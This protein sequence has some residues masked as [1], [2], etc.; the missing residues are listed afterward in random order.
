MRLAFFLIALLAHVDA[1]AQPYPN[2]PVRFVVGFTPGGSSDTVARIVGQRLGE[3]LGQQVV[4]DNRGGASGGVAAELVAKSRPDGYTL[5]LATPGSLTIAPVLKKHLPYDPDRELAPVTQIATTSAILLTTPSGPASVRDL[6]AAAKK[7]PR[8]L[9][10]ASSG[11]G[12]SNHLAAELFNTMAGIEMVHVPYKGSGQTLPALLSGEV[13]LVFGPIV[14][15]LPQLR[16][17]RVKALGVTGARRSQAAPDIPT[18]AEAGLPGFEIDS[19]YG[20]A[21]AANTPAPILQRL[22]TE[23][24]AIVQEREVRERLIREGADPVGSTPQEFAAYIKTERRKW[25]DVA[26]AANIKQE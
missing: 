3:R 12:S 16:Q 15:A 22:M 10:Y 17:G 8:R 6:I 11:F 23:T 19:W 21:V 4:I 9:N 5:L 7:Q 13:Q 18:I 24:R 1:W 25:V 26:R 2:R 20:I 14:P